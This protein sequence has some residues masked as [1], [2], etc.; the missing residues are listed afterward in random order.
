MKMDAMFAM[1]ARCGRFAS[2]ELA[3]GQAKNLCLGDLV[4][5]ET[6]LFARRNGET[7]QFTRNERAL[8]L[9][10]TRNP[11]RLMRR[12]RL[13]D[14]IA[15]SE[16]TSSDRNIDF[17]VNRLRTKLGDNAKSPMYIATQ[18]G[19]GYVWI[20]EPLPAKPIAPRSPAALG[21]RLSGDRTGSRTRGTSF[22][23]ASVLPGRSASRHDCRRPRRWPKGRREP[24]T[25]A[26]LPPTDCAI[27]CR[28]A[29]TPGTGP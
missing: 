17:L 28:W 7:I 13:L 15:S 10:F 3:M 18:Y 2:A 12:S 5:D 29:F 19:E 20:A 16:S 21:G 14:E 24:R 11:R 4:L 22:Q 6:C 8:L 1:V 23:R 9:A 25:A 27:S 26:R